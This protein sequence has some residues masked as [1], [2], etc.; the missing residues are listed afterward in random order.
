MIRKKTSYLILFLFFLLISCL[1]AQTTKMI[2]VG[3]YKLDVSISGTGNYTVVFESGLGDNLMIWQKVIKA[4][5]NEAKVVSYSRAGLGNSEK[6]N[7]PISLKLIISELNTVLDSLNIDSNIILV[8]HSMGGQIVRAFTKEYMHKVVGLVLVEGSHENQNEKFKN[9]DP[10]G[11]G[12]IDLEEKEFYSKQSEIV[13]EEAELFYKLQKRDPVQVDLPEIPLVVITSVLH[14]GSNF[15]TAERRKIWRE[16]HC[17]WFSNVQNGMHIVT[18]RSGHY[19]HQS[20]PEL[21]ANAIIYVLYNAQKITS[22]PH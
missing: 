10:E 4:L 14:E 16:L 20:E 3:G 11:W 18:N 8:G 6:R 9:Q 1:N 13:R 17:E 22:N 2:D 15:W 7:Q 19:I 5:N 21:V 12:K